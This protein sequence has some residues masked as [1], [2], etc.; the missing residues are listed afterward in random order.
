VDDIVRATILA[1][2]DDRALRHGSEGAVS[3]TR[4]QT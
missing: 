2:A 4:A 1:S 3:S